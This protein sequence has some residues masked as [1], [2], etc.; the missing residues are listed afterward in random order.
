MVLI[1]LPFFDGLKFE[2]FKD[3]WPCSR[4]HNS[5]LPTAEMLC[6]GLWSTERVPREDNG[7]VNSNTGEVY[8]TQKDNLQI[9]TGL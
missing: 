8:K 6:S 4:R 1:S 2:I 5:P 7:C 9:V 3:F